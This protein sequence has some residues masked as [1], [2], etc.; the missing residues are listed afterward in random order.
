MDLRSLERVACCP[1]YLSVQTVYFSEQR[2]LS[3]SSLLWLYQIGID[4]AVAKHRQTRLPTV[5]VSLERPS[6]T[7]KVQ[8][9]YI[10]NEQV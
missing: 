7:L 1:F 3:S 5:R 10:S 2:G 9:R 6:L 8:H 4:G